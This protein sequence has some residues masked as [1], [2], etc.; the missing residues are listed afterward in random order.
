MQGPHLPLACV[1]PGTERPSAAGAAQP[2]S[3]EIGLE[4]GFGD[5]DRQHG[6]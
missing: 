2:S 6:V 5:G 4:N 1:P 3:G